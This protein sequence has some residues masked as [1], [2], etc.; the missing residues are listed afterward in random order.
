VS[1]ELELLID[2]EEMTQKK[3]DG[4]WNVIRRSRELPSNLG[5]GGKRKE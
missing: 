5:A 2:D 3:R 1:G 4:K